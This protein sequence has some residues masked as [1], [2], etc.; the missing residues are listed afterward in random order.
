MEDRHF[1][2]SRDSPM[3]RYPKACSFHHRNM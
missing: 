1:I 2:C 3:S